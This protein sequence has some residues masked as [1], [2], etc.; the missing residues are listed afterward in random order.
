LPS[1]NEFNDSGSYQS[2]ALARTEQQN[3]IEGMTDAK[4]VQYYALFCI[5]AAT[6]AV[7]NLITDMDDRFVDLSPFPGWISTR[8]WTFNE[9]D[10]CPIN[11]GGEG[12]FDGIECQNGKVTAVKLNQR[13]LTGVFPSEVTLLASDGPAATGAGDLQTLELFNNPFLF[14]NADN[15]WMEF[16][17]SSLGTFQMSTIGFFYANLLF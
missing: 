7:P 14:N 12:N 16:L 6:H 5:Y 17:G 3:G 11:V 4:I 15:S 1:G 13:F 9:V 2:K 10:P 8:G